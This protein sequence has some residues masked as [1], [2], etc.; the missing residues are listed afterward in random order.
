MNTKPNQITEA[1]VIGFLTAKRAELIKR[2]GIAYAFI[3]V[4][5]EGCG[6]PLWTAYV[7]GSKH[8]QGITCDAA[9]A[10]Q[11]RLQSDDGRIERAKS[12]RETAARLLAEAERLEAGK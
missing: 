7:D 3:S 10:E 6:T 5:I 12:A 8:T 11:V 4:G 9:I 1:D 2:T